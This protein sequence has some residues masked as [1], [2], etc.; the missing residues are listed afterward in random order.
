VSLFSC[1][2][3]R[4]MN[5]LNRLAAA[6]RKVLLS[7]FAVPAVNERRHA[8]GFKSMLEV[9]VN[10]PFPRLQRSKLSSGRAPFKHATCMNG[11]AMG[12]MNKGDAKNHLS[13]RERNGKRLYRPVG[14]SDASGYLGQKTR[15]SHS[16][17]AIAEAPLPTG[18]TGGE[19]VTPDGVASLRPA[20]LLSAP[21]SAQA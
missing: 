8:H 12:F 20:S 4:A 13:L 19:A 17:P 14:P 15:R 21:V 16:G 10:F 2:I 11:A 5:L 18:S 7:R 3:N 9:V 1:R 6:T